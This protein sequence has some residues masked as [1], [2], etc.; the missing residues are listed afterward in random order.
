M[1]TIVSVVGRVI[2]SV[3]T[4]T[5]PVN[6]TIRNEEGIVLV[7]APRH[8][9]PDDFAVGKLVHVSGHLHSFLHRRCRSNHIVLKAV[10]VSPVATPFDPAIH[11]AEIIA[12]L[13]VAK[14]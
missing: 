3:N 4:E 9:L 13:L 6:F 1:K 10:S 11:F 7:E 12:S 8:L 2:G 5:D 14:R